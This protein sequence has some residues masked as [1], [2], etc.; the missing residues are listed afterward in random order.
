MVCWI[1][2]PDPLEYPET[3]GELP[4]AVQLKDAPVTFEAMVIPVVFPLQITCDE[5]VKFTL[6]TGNTVT[7]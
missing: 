6:A 5:G 4:V 2:D 3:A 1:T 7:V